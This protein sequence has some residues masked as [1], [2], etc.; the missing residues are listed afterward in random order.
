MLSGSDGWTGGNQ[1]RFIWIIPQKELTLVELN[2]KKHSTNV[3]H[4]EKLISDEKI[5][6]FDNSMDSVY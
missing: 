2:S 1:K 4:F 5:E 6:W 3:V